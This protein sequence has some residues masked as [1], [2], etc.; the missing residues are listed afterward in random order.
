MK[1]AWWMVLACAL[2]WGYG[3]ELKVSEAANAADR[4][5]YRQPAAEWKEGLPIGNGTIGAMVLG[6]VE[7]DRLALNHTRLWRKKLQG[8]DNPKAARHLTAIR[9]L[10]FEGKTV[11]ASNA[12]NQ[13]LGT[14]P[15]HGVDPYQPVGDLRLHFPDHKQATDYRRELDLS[16]GIVRV[17]YR[18]GETTFSRETFASN[19]DGVLVVRLAADKPK[20]IACTVELSRVADPECTLAP[21]GEPGRIGFVGEFKEGVRFAAAAAVV[22]GGL[23]PPETGGGTAKLR[24]DGADEVLILLS[25]AVG[26]EAADPK[27]SCTAQLARVIE[28]PDSDFAKLAKLHVVQHQALYRRVEL[29]LGRDTRADVPTDQRLAD[30]KAGRPDPDLEALYFRF[31]RYLLLSCSRP[32]GLPANL[33]GMW[34]EEI[35]PPWNC[36]FHHDVNIQMAYWPAEVCNLTECAMPLFD[37]VDSLLPG[38]RAAAQD[39]Y[40]CRGVFI[41]ITSDPWGKC[42]KVERGWDEWTGAAAWLAQHYWWHYEFTGDTEFLRTRAYPLL[43]EIALFYQDYLVADPRPASPHKGRLV[44]VPSQSPENRFVGGI[45]PVS[46]CIGGTMDFELI[47]DVFTHLIAANGILGLDADQRAR[48]AAILKRIP[49]LQTGKH[50]Q[51]QEW[52]EDYDEAEPGHRHFSH[53][54]AL[55]PGDE[56]TLRGTPEL[57]KAARVSLE[58]RLAAKGGHTGWS[59]S[60]VVGLWARLGEG[61][62]AEEHLRHL[63]T[64]FATSSLLDLHPPRIFQI[65]GNFG[66][67]AGIAEMLLQ[68]HPSAGSG[69]ACELSLL[70][71]LPK[72]WPEGHVKG[73][74]ARGG[75]ELDI[76]WSD[77]RLASATLRSTF[78][79]PCRVRAQAPLAVKADGAALDVEQR[80]PAQCLFATTAGK[81]YTLTPR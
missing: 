77:G 55:F 47:H 59:R 7:R 32:G 48:W 36:D 79:G 33:Q 80:E 67:T 20:A 66:G 69:Q 52:L 38:A 81:T 73:L 3:G 11:E 76:A 13:L 54:F 15:I 64:D 39:L 6:G 58:R 14:Q 17:T 65:D 37:Y 24:I 34:N 23:K 78:G 46:L 57:A 26:Q 25:I 49:P 10:F 53:L 72:A 30:L 40:G 31:G 16:T 1:H 12:A 5:W 61:D 71:A 70:P 35:K 68:S 9:K 41:P 62:L 45:G 75:F 50:G 42:L 18:H 56:I 74:R 19:A 4:L 29:R 44:T 27:A 43:K 51:L 28:R 8:R 2:A 21:W 22:A 63:I 60:W